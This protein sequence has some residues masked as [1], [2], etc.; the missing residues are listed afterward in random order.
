MQCMLPYWFL[1]RLDSSSFNSPSIESDSNFTLIKVIY[2]NKFT[3][4]KSMAMFLS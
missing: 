1:F 4:V 3:Y 2:T